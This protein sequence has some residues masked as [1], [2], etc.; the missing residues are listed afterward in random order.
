[1]PAPSNELQDAI[2]RIRTDLDSFTDVAV[3]TLMYDGYYL[4]SHTLVP[5]WFSDFVPATATPQSPPAGRW[6]F[7]PPTL[8][9][10]ELLHHIKVASNRLF[11]VF[12]LWNSWGMLAWLAAGVIF[13]LAWAF[14]P[15]VTLNDVLVWPVRLFGYTGPVTIGFF[16]P[17]RDWFVWLFPM[18]EDIID[19]SLLPVGDLFNLPIHVPF[20]L[21][22][23][24]VVYAVYQLWSRIKARLLK[25]ERRRVWRFVRFLIRWKRSPLFPIA[26]VWAIVAAL[27]AKVHLLVFDRLF[28]KAGKV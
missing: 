25:G 4:A 23:A 8:G 15:P 10:P 20:T 6:S 17:L 18:L 26:V 16:L 27:V 7:Y 28:L 2:S 3:Y 13:V 1:M 9:K 24:A 14:F 22:V 12:R 19:F 5:Q 21:L 11:K